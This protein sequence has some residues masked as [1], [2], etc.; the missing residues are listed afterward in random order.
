MFMERK[1]FSSQKGKVS[2]GQYA[3]VAMF[4]TKNSLNQRTV[5]FSVVVIVLR[6]SLSLRKTEPKVTKVD[7]S[8]VYRS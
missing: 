4:A 6:R 1:G 7:Q 8:L 3:Y 5:K 2:Q